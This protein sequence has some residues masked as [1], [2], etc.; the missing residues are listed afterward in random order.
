MKEKEILL[1][2][3]SIW[4][5]LS[6]NDKD[7]I[8]KNSYFKNFLAKEIVHSSFKSCFG[9]II[10]KSGILK[11][12]LNSKD[13]KT[14]TLFRI[15]NNDYCVISMSCALSTINFDIEIM[16]EQDTTLLIL[17]MDIFDKISQNNIYVENFAYKKIAE[18]LSN[19]ISALEQISFMSL[20][21]RIEKYIIDETLF[22]NNNTISITHDELAQN[23]SSSREGVSRTL[24]QMQK[25]GIISLSRGKI[26]LLKKSKDL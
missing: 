9:L 8:F 12:I 18:R 5:N 16:A 10:V 1:K 26:T 3:L 17:P 22:Y 11:A 6:E 25:N 7:I 24:K 20:E 14:A 21:E 13:G 23:I 2:K 4:D 19:V 15:K